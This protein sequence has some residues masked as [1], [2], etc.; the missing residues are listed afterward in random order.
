M[1]FKKLTLAAAI[2]I[3]LASVATV[4]AFA[5]SCGCNVAPMP[6]IVSPACPVPCAPA[7]CDPQPACPAPCALEDPCC[8]PAPACEC[9]TPQPACPVC[10][11]ACDKPACGLAD[12]ICGKTKEGIMHYAYPENVFSGCKG[13]Q[14]DP[15]NIGFATNN[16]VLSTKGCSCGTMTSNSGCGCNT[17]P[18][19]IG[20][21]SGGVV[22][23]GAAAGMP[24]IG[25]GAVVSRNCC[26][27]ADKS[28][29]SCGTDTSACPVTIQTQSSLQAMKKSLVP[30][31]IPSVAGAASPMA[32]PSAFCDVPDSYWAVCD[33]NKLVAA[34]VIAGY[35][36][37][38]FKPTLP[39]SRAEFASLI[40]NGLELSRCAESCSASFCDVP[41]LHWANNSVQ[42]SV[43]AGYM[44]GY[45]D[46]TFK[47]GI[48]I[49]RA[50]AI[51][52]IA[53]SFKCELTDCEAD[54]IL[55]QYQDA[56]KVPAWAKMAVAKAL[57]SNLLKDTPCPTMINPC[58][59]ASRAEI[60]SMLSQARIALCIDKPATTGCAC[61]CE[62]KNAFVETCET[63]DIPTL[64]VSMKDQISA[65]H[66][67]VGDH[68]AAQTIDPITINGVCYPACSKV[69]GM[70]VDVQRPNSQCDGAMKIALTEIKNGDCTVKLPRQILNAQVDKTKNQNWFSRAVQ[71]PFTLVGTTLGIAGRTVGGIVVNA[72]NAAESVTNSVGVGTGELFQFGKAPCTCC[73][74]GST[75]FGAAFRSYKDAVV[76][77]AEA[78]VD[79]VRTSLSG[80]A[81]V[82]QNANSEL[83]YLI[84]P[85]GKCISS[86]NI[87]ER[88]TFAFGTGEK[89]CCEK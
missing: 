59:D 15:F 28:C 53:K 72:G 77:L 86:I 55:S 47:P 48:P 39:V 7:C 45:P 44:A 18:M 9:C 17:I 12:S 40:A 19:A 46:C 76:T 71:M 84:N 64:K 79:V 83:G 1:K 50:E 25:D 58:E 61:E 78:P 6:V 43:G 5:G 56:C 87:N 75:N 60:A 68:F 38:T 26:S 3:G 10:T 29:C 51:T 24:C 23:T 41:A 88:V 81:G 49:S 2:S 57:K 62:K 33:I 67:D 13:V 65:S 89:T 16:G 70:I 8:E 36:D 21:S 52:T 42:R 32:A 74:G 35:P 80:A 66:S 22:T 69:N 54:Q 85:D 82:L 20:S 27:T 11:P 63:V 14:A 30:F 34:N 37:R 73:E 4:G 31:D